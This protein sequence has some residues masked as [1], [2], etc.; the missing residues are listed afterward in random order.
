MERQNPGGAYS[1][2]PAILCPR[3]AFDFSTARAALSLT[4]RSRH[5]RRN[6]ANRQ[7]RRHAASNRCDLSSAQ[8]CRELDML[9]RHARPTLRVQIGE[10]ETTMRTPPP[11]MRK[12]FG[13]H[14][15][16]KALPR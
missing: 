15:E 14:V 7:I 10:P 5:P 2:G 12:G 3:Q 6:A 16:P 11:S 13:G 4:I 1:F 9:V 8:A